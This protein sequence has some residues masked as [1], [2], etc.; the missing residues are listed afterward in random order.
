MEDFGRVKLV[1]PQI[2]LDV[3]FDTVQPS[4]RPT[5]DAALPAQ[6]QLARDTPATAINTLET[7]Q[8]VAG[9]AIAGGGKMRYPRQNAAISAVA[10][11]M[12]S[13]YRYKYS[14]KYMR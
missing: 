3:A 9:D 5:R 2:V 7:L 10:L 11:A 8:K 4:K 12:T 14:G 6:R 1:E 13:G